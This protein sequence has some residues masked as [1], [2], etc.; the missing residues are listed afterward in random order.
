M[1]NHPASVVVM[2]KAPQPGR[3]KTRLIP[4]LGADGAARLAAELIRHTTH[5]AAQTAA[6]VWVA[7]DPP[8][9]IHEA[10]LLAAGGARLFG[11][12][13]SDLGQRISAAVNHV[14]TETSGPV[15]VI[16]T[17][18]PTLTA[19]VLTGAAQLLRSGTEA[20]IGPALDGG[21]YLIGL[22]RPKPAA[23]AIDPR[24]WGGDQVLDATLAALRRSQTRVV[25]LSALRDLDTPDDAAALAADPAT[26]PAVT[27]LLAT[28]GRAA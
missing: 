22:T 27:A 16:G 26:P 24:L 20:V 9:A 10:A 2:A 23:F 12:R 8:D 28:A 17:D 11:Q 21:Y 3:A 25:L 6:D 13:G 5:T 1:R 7:V 4:L 18:T 15:I 14:W 19:R